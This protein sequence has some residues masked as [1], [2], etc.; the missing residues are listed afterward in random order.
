MDAE[1]ELRKKTRR[2]YEELTPFKFFCK[3]CSFKTKR[4]SH[5]AKHLGIHD[6]VSKKNCFDMKIISIVDFL[7]SVS[8]QLI[9]LSMT[10]YSDLVSL[11]V[12][13]LYNCENCSFTTIR[14]SHLRRHEMSHSQTTYNCDQCTYKTDEMKL[15]SRHVKL[16]HKREEDP[17][18]PVEILQCSHCPYKT[19]KPYHFKRHLRVHSS[20]VKSSSRVYQCDQCTY[21]TNR[22]EHYIRHVNNVHSNKRPYL[23][24]FCGKA[25]KRPDAL[26]Q[27]RITHGGLDS[28]NIQFKCSVCQKKCRSQAH[29]NEHQAVHSNIRMFLCEICGASFKTRSVQRK[30][31]VT[32]HKNPRAHPC[33]HCDKRFNTNYAL[34]RHLRLHL[35]GGD[36][37]VLVSLNNDSSTIALLGDSPSPSHDQLMRTEPSFSEQL[38]TNPPNTLSL[39]FRPNIPTADH[40]SDVSDGATVVT[41]QESFDQMSNSLSQGTSTFIQ[42]SEATTALLYLTANFTQF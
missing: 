35:T 39:T 27:H 36:D 42:T 2:N 15:L 17:P 11:Q 33:E 9:S 8:L 31:I 3:R 1:E 20:E 30:H 40:I 21:K 22:K 6:K 34:R 5:Y 38:I 10:S 37:N 29:L 13:T 26:K 24:D 4:E 7:H 23:C 18:S 32:I 19:T 28:R 12:K 41:I 14:L 25:F 16:K